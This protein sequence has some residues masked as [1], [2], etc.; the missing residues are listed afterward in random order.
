MILSKIGEQKPPRSELSFPVSF[1]QF[2]ESSL[3]REH[4]EGMDCGG[5]FKTI[6]DVFYLLTPQNDKY[7]ESEIK[8][9]KVNN[10]EANQ[11][12]RMTMETM[13]TT[14]NATISLHD[15]ILVIRVYSPRSKLAPE[16]KRVQRK[17]TGTYEVSEHRGRDNFSCRSEGMNENFHFSLTPKSKIL[18][19]TRS[20][21]NILRFFMFKNVFKP[22]F[23]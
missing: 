10:I 1:I 19:I 21:N 13:E 17:E 9:A 7:P 5:D 23:Q 15:I 12:W 22:F 14:E 11:L 20:Q 2:A 6:R 18:F 16:K 3:F 8:S 4:G